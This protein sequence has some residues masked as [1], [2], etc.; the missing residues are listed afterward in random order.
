MTIVVYESKKSEKVVKTISAERPTGLY[1]ALIEYCSKA[2]AKRIIKA[3]ENNLLYGLYFDK[4]GKI[5]AQ[6]K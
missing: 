4:N 3:Q 1:G 2:Q 6:Y 5:R